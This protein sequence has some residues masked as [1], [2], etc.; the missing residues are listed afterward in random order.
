M[1]LPRPRVEA[2]DC[3]HRPLNEMANGRARRGFLIDGRR[4]R[5]AVVE[6]ETNRGSMSSLVVELHHRRRRVGSPC[7]ARASTK[8]VS[9]VIRED[10]EAAPPERYEIVVTTVS[11][12]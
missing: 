7:V 4:L 5:S 6:L 9:V 11:G 12:P 10:Q 2:R 3:A 1:V 8:P